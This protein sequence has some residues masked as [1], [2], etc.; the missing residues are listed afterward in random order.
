MK[1]KRKFHRFEFGT[2]YGYFII[3]YINNSLC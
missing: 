3:K 2:P 1:K